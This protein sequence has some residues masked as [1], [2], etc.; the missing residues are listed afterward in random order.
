MLPDHIH[1][2]LTNQRVLV[3]QIKSKSVGSAK[4]SKKGLH[5][6]TLIPLLPPCHRSDKAP[7]NGDSPDCWDETQLLHPLHFYAPKSEQSSGAVPVLGSLG[8]PSAY[9]HSV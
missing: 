2:K 4:A 6:T 8:T 1:P 7:S 9:R 3:F 5:T